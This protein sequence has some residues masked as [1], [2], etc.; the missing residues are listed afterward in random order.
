MYHAQKITQPFDVGSF[1]CQYSGG[2][3]SLR[4]VTWMR[5]AFY[6]TIPPPNFFEGGGDIEY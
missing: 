1:L 2:A 3:A 5:H 6:T 4:V